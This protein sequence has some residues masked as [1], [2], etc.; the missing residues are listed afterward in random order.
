MNWLAY[1]LL[2]SLSF[3]VQD[4][5]SYELLHVDKIGSAAV[6]TI[7]HCIFVMLGLGISYIT[8][9]VTVANDIKTI[10]SKYKL[11]ITL[12]GICALIGNIML[13]WAYQIGSN[14]NPGII[15]TISNGAVIVS[16]ILAYLF[17][18]KSV[19][20]KQTLG[21]IVMLFAFTMGAM[22][23]KLFGI[24]DQS[25]KSDKS[26][27][28]DNSHKTDKKKDDKKSNNHMWVLIAA[29]SA[30]S[31]GGL[32]FFQYMVTQKDKKL[33]MISLAI[34]VALVE[35]IIGILIYGLTHIPGLSNIQQGP[36]KNYKD[37][38]NKLFQLKYLPF[39][40]S[41]ALFDGAGLATLLKS[42]RIAPN[43]GFSD[44]IS[45]SYSV[46]QSILTFLIYG[47]K[48]DITQALSIIVSILG[49]TLISI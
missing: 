40:S 16:T 27:K 3:G 44:V 38:I 17:F 41:T 13:Y 4:T 26:D 43:P 34:T 23:N 33:N 1:A 5:I 8:G 48:M 24:K 25:K 49:I 21:I 47:E 14:I 30:L 32:S 39:T 36:F 28:S 42:Y 15:T 12:A 11:L 35:A 22:G 46:I 9:S 10:L 19:T 45:D 2:S 6:N 29:L 37:D 31:Y 7:V 18:N 20:L